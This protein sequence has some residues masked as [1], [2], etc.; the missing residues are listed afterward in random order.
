LT[1]YIIGC[2]LLQV[3]NTNTQKQGKTMDKKELIKRLRKEA[4]KAQSKVIATTF[5]ANERNKAFLQIEHLLQ[6]KINEVN[7]L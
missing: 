6:S 2:I 3:I 1:F 4:R 5:E 7:S